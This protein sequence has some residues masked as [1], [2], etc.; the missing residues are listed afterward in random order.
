MTP[1]DEAEA[2]SRSRQGDVQAF[3]RLVEQY[4]ARVYGVCYWLLGEVH[5]AED[6]SQETFMSAF[7]AIQRFRGGSFVAWLLAIA[8]NECYDQLRA[9]RR[10]D[11][12]EVTQEDGE[13]APCLF[14]DRSEVPEERVLRAELSSTLERLVLAL[15][16][17]QRLAIVLRDV[18]GYSYI[19]IA[20]ATGWPAGTIKSRVSRGRTRL[21]TAL[22]AAAVGIAQPSSISARD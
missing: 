16:A 2:I 20:A 22:Q 6:A 13:E 9:R 17:D 19:E 15:P 14:V 12:H 10:Q 18:Q 11:V 3:N 21:R 7:R 5:A 8:K 4:Q 1:I